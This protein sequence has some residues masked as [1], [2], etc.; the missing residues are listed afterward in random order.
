MY[1]SGGS[2]ACK[3]DYGKIDYQVLED[4]NLVTKTITLPTATGTMALLSD[5][6]TNHVTTNTEQS[7][8]AMKIFIGNKLKVQSSSS[9]YAMYNAT[10]VYLVSGDQTTAYNIDTISRSKGGDS[11]NT[12]FYTFPNKSGTFAMLSDIG[13]DTIYGYL[14][15]ANGISIAKTSAGDKVEVKINNEGFSIGD[16][17]GALNKGNYISL[18]ARANS[19]VSYFVMGYDLTDVFRI[20]C[21]DF[22]P[23]MI[24]RYT[25]VKPTDDGGLTLNAPGET[26]KKVLTEGNVKTVGG[27]S[28]YGTG[29]IDNVKYMD[30]GDQH[31]V[32]INSTGMTVT[33]NVNFT[34]NI[35]D[36][37]GIK[38][39]TSVD[40]AG[41]YYL[42]ENNVKTIGGQSIYGSGDIPI[43]GG[44][45]DVDTLIAL[46]TGSNGIGIAKN[47]AG[48]KVNIKGAIP[49]TVQFTQLTETIGQYTV[50]LR[51]DVDMPTGPYA[52]WK[53]VCDYVDSYY[54][55]IGFH[56]NGTSEATSK[57]LYAEG[58][59]NNVKTLFMVAAI[60]TCTGIT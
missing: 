36:A 24:L 39:I 20:N 56:L 34:A 35:I 46:L 32:V 38:Y 30:S 41:K 58:P 22:K 27:Q 1:T 10:Q 13:V 44:T 48:D 18:T 33:D 17:D 49:I 19:N 37:S 29:D 59:F 2:E 57:L 55:F 8:T 12:Y 11:G 15:G 14:Q 45:V 42:R 5:I 54:D 51:P 3:Y 25:T 47:A 23:T 31:N 4:G 28:I 9:V 6:P 53:F 7:I 26:P 40:T 50:T 52:N 60:L 16:F 43:N 21:D